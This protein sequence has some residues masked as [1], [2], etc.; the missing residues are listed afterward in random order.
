MAL[1]D[2]DAFAHIA[3]GQAHASNGESAAAVLDY[4]EAIGINPSNAL[5]R[6]LLDSLLSRSGKAEAAIEHLQLAIELSPSDPGIASFYARLVAANL[7]LGRYQAAVGWGQKA[8]Q[9]NVA[10]IGRVPY[11]SALAHLGRAKEARAA[12]EDLQRLEPATTVEFVQRRILMPHQPYMDHLLEGC[13][14]AGLQEN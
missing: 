6:S 10:C 4:E 2:K 8:T 1:D 14:L 11:A 12:L 13:R 5:A 9:K 7:Y 3:L